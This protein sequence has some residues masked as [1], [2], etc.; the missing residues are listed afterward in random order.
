MCLQCKGHLVPHEQSK[1]IQCCNEKDECN[2]FLRP[3]YPERPTPETPGFGSADSLPFT[4]LLTTVT[5][6]LTLV[7]LVVA[8]VYVKNRRKEMQR[9]FG[10]Y[11]KGYATEKYPKME[12]SY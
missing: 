5:F 2:K 11:G 12:V 7:L 9:K 3:T 10:L 4:V 6:C 1:S 8:I